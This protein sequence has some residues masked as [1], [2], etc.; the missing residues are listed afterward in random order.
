MAYYKF[1]LGIDLVDVPI[2]VNVFGVKV[3]VM[4]DDEED[5]YDDFENLFDDDDVANSTELTQS[6]KR[7]GWK[8]RGNVLPSSFVRSF[9]TLVKKVTNII[10]FII[11]IIT[12]IYSLKIWRQDYHQMKIWKLGY[13]YYKA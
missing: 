3:L 6:K 2:N 4:D 8:A 9:K 12:I 5:K 10:T 11:S 1:Y 7:R 13:H